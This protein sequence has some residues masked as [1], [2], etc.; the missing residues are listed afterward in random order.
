MHLFSQST[1]LP[2][3][4]GIFVRQAS[5]AS[6]LADNS[7]FFSGCKRLAGKF[8]TELTR[9]FNS[10]FLSPCRPD[11]SDQQHVI[12]N[13]IGKS[14]I[15]GI[16]VDWIAKNLYFSNVFPHETYIEVSW[17]DG[18]YRKVIYKSTTDNPRYKLMN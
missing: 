16:A 18:K 4:P 12:K 14:G 5:G 13:G 10:S 15:R 2:G 1:G 6:G 8:K 3:S 11:G 9:N 17:L 7:K